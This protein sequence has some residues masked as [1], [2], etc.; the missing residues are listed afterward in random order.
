MTR[1]KLDE[2]WSYVGKMQRRVQAD[3]S[4]ELGDQYVFIGHR[5]IE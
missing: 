4:A 1:I 2:L 3:D 5:C